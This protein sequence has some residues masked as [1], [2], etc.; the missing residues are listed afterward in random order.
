MKGQGRSQ[1]EAGESGDQREAGK[2][3]DS[4]YCGKSESAK[5]VPFYR[6]DKTPR[7][8]RSCL[9]PRV[10]ASWW[11]AAS[12]KAPESAPKGSSR[13]S[14][15]LRYV[16]YRRRSRLQIGLKACVDQTA[17][18]GEQLSKRGASIGINAGEFIE[19]E[20][21]TQIFVWRCYLHSIIGNHR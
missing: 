16:E 5:R 11:P 4:E 17:G 2:N 1:A 20:I 14:V 12:P 21:A 19:D 9:A 6:P 8:G 3:R 15:T 7:S 10:E 13:R 18:R